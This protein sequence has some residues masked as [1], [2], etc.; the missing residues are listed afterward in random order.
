MKELTMPS[1]IVCGML[2]GSRPGTTARARNPAIRPDD[3]Q[4]DDEPDHVYV[5]FRTARRRNPCVPSREPAN[6]LTTPMAV[7]VSTRSAG[8]RSSPARRCRPMVV[9]A[10]SVSARSSPSTRST[11]KCPGEKQA[12][13]DPRTGALDEDQ[14]DAVSW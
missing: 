9:V 6:D 12:E 8:G 10:R 1:R 4:E 11:L 2:I 5:S 7:R 3:Q 14:P 13:R